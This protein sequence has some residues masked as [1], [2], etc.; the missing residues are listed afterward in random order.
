MDV[1]GG[2][3]AAIVDAWDDIE[4]ADRGNSPRH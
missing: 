2:T 4:T 1:Y 3:D